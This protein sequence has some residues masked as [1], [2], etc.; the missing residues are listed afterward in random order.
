MNQEATSPRAWGEIEAP[1]ELCSLVLSR[2][3]FARRRQ[4][5]IRAATFGLLALAFGAALVPLL[6]YAATELYTSGFYEYASLLFSNGG[7]VFAS[8]REVGLLLVESVPSIA[9]LLV[10]SATITLVFLVRRVV[11]SA[12]V[13]FMRIA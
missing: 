12:R 4:A 11:L 8:W 1:A 10:A 3:A 7:F 9:L 5:R 13:A 6:G 2:V